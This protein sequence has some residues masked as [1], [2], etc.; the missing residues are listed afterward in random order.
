MGIKTLGHRNGWVRR[1]GRL[2]HTNY[3]VR[4]MVLAGNGKKKRPSVTLY[5][6]ALTEFAYGGPALGDPFGDFMG[7]IIG[8]ENWDA[9]PQWMKDIRLK[10]NPA[11]V[12]QTALNVVKPKGL[13]KV[14]TE[15]EKV[16]VTV[17]VKNPVTGGFSRVSPQNASAAYQAYGTGFPMWSTA[18]SAI[19]D[20]PMWVWVAGGV[21]VFMV[22]MM[23]AKK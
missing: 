14:L 16:G 9:R 23:V 22:V 18:K 17:N 1:N 15:A 4:G 2:G 5:D 20:V 3:M 13:E 7:S 21:G 12:A 6:T 11:T 8:E 10:V 19:G